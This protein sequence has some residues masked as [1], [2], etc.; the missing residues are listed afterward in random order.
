MVEN[1]IGAID[2][3]TE[4]GEIHD[5]YRIAYF[6][7]HFTQMKQAVDEGVDLLGYTSWGTIDLI[8]ASSSQITKRYGFIHVDQDDLGAGSGD[9]RRKDS[10]WW[11]QKVIATNGDEL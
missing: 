2:E 3:V 1:G 10:F 8:S 7:E 4:R 6:R 11:Y 9:R 5:P